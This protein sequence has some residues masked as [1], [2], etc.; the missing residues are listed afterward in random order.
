[1]WGWHMNRHIEQQDTLQYSEK[2][3]SLNIGTQ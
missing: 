1:M 3:P 2:D